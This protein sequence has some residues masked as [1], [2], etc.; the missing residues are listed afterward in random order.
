MSFRTTLGHVRQVSS[1]L[2]SI[3]HA[4]TKAAR[5]RTTPVPRSHGRKI[6][7]YSHL[8]TNQVVYSL[9]KALKNNP[10]IKQL[11]FNGKKTVPS[12]LRKD[13][14]APLAQIS[15]GPGPK[16]YGLSVYQKLREYRRRHELEWDDSLMRDADGKVI[17]KKKRGR[18]IN[19]QKANSIADIATVLSKIGT[20]EG[21]E[22]GLRSPTSKDLPVVEVKWI[23]MLDAEFAETWTENVVHDQLDWSKNNRDPEYWSKRWAALDA[24]KKQGSLSHAEQGKGQQ[25]YW[26]RMDEERKQWYISQNKLHEMKPRKSVATTTVLSKEDRA[27]NR[28]MIPAKRERYTRYL[29]RKVE[30]FNVLDEVWAKRESL[31]PD[32]AKPRENV[33]IILDRQKRIRKK[34]E[35]RAMKKQAAEAHAA[36]KQAYQPE[37]LATK[38]ARQTEFWALQDKKRQE[39]YLREGKPLA[40]MKPRNMKATPLPIIPTER[41]LTPQSSKSYLLEKVREKE[42][43]RQREFYAAEE[44]KRSKFKFSTSG[45]L[46]RKTTASSK[47]EIMVEPAEVD[48]Y[49]VKTAPPQTMPVSKETHR[50]SSK[51]IQEHYGQTPEI[52]AKQTAWG[53]EMARKREMWYASQGKAL[54]DKVPGYLNPMVHLPKEKASIEV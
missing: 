13:L 30:R 47:P 21:E 51:D 40:E 46:P 1:P 28:R 7:V 11:P 3:R 39:Y 44:K 19:D 18:Q 9:T 5:R 29:A 23:N 6:Y 50:L 24:F 53:L 35:Y 14:W 31:G 49:L 26:A 34:V 8:Q 15:F 25:A 37:D 27:L 2:T 20:S 12:A 41:N 45:P 38:V 4:S 33:D 36:A 10:S 43:E 32:E 54:P 17:P 22:I 42:V 48:K 16:E 52:V